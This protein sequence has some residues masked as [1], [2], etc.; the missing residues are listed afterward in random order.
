MR[1]SM[2]TQFIAKKP[3]RCEKLEHMSE[4]ISSTLRISTTLA[5][6]LEIKA[7]ND[8]EIGENQEIYNVFSLDYETRHDV[9]HQIATYFGEELDPMDISQRKRNQ[10]VRIAEKHYWDLFKEL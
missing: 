5:E 3:A 9:V 10:S 4:E 6:Q 2:V 8:W 7:L 1:K